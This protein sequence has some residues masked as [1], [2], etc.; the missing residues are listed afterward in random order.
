ML[1]YKWIVR[2]QPNFSRKRWIAYNVASKS[3][4]QTTKT[5]EVCTIPSMQ[6]VNGIVYILFSFVEDRCSFVLSVLFCCIK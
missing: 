5:K 6:L 4:F 1:R 2:N 3:M